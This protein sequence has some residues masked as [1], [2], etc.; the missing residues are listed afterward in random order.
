MMIY[1]KIA[2]II[3][4][5]T[6]LI[7]AVNYWDSYKNTNQRYFLFL[8]IFST[9][10]DQGALLLSM[11]LEYRINFLY[12]ILI[13][14]LGYFYLYWFNKI[15]NNKKLIKLL[16]VLFSFSTI[17]SLVFLH[18]YDDFFTYLLTIETI[19]ILICSVLCFT[20]LIKDNKVVNYYKSQRFWIVVGLLVFYI[21]FLPLHLLMSIIKANTV[22]YQSAILILNVILYGC[23]C[24][25]FVVSKFKID[26]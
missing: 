23:Y 6:A 8:I 25:S 2:L 10:I 5:L 7:F 17:L 11:C 13:I 14:V 19:V 9:I 18:F 4:Q 12:N 16:V 22:E 21:G 15:I 3:V 1:F 26:E 24:Y 20:E